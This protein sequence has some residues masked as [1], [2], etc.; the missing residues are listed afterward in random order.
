M[1]PH[2]VEPMKLTC[3]APPLRARTEFLPELRDFFAGQRTIGAGCIRI[4]DMRGTLG[5][6]A[7]GS[8]GWYG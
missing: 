6:E 1:E 5:R 2:Q 8:F 7:P 3:N 4:A